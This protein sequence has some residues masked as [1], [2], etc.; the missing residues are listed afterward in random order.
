MI[1]ITTILYIVVLLL[2]ILS[3]IGILRSDKYNDSKLLYGSPAVFV[4]SIVG[5]LFLW[6]ATIFVTLMPD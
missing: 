4:L 1:Q 6:L 5:A 2:F 3:V